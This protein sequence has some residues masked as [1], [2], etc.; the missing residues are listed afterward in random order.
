MLRDEILRECQPQSAA[1]GAAVPGRVRPVELQATMAHAARALAFFAT[2]LHLADDVS[3]W[4][5]VESAYRDRTRQLFDP[6]AGRYRD[7][8]G[9]ETQLF[10]LRRDA[11]SRFRN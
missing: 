3:R 7:W 9:G 2:E 4:Q 6:E 5:A 8:V 10:E 1:A 11:I